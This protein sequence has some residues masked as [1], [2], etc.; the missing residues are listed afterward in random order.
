[1]YKIEELIDR[2]N[3][4]HY[5]KYKYVV[6]TYTK[7]SEKMTIICPIHREFSQSMHEHINKKHGCPKC[8]VEKRVSQRQYD[9][10]FFIE[11]AKEV[12]G[13]KYDYSKVEYK[14][15]LTH[16]TIICPIHGEFSQRPDGHLQGKGCPMCHNGIKKERTFNKKMSFNDFVD[17]CS[18][19]FG[20]KLDFKLLHKSKPSY[21]YIFNNKR[22][23][24]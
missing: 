24:M 4:V 10:D 15:S 5:N 22:V 19:K 17:K 6:S 1:M 11:K 21:F 13:D 23:N 9:T 8:G 18:E 3:K 14:N 7:M 20:K 16:V 2:A 12:H